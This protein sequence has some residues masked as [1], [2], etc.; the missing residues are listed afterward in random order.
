MCLIIVKKVGKPMPTQAILSIAFDNNPDGFGIAYTEPDWRY[1]RIIKG[2]MSKK[3]MHKMIA[4]IPQPKKKCIIFHFRYATEGQV[5][6]ENCHPF[7]LSNRDEDLASLDITTPMA[8]A[9]NGMIWDTG[10]DW[11][12]I[13]NDDGLAVYSWKMSVAQSDTQKYIKNYLWGMGSSLFNR[14]VCKLVQAH[15]NS[16]FV[17]LS[18]AKHMILGDFYIKDGLLFSNGSY[19]PDY[20]KVEEVALPPQQHTCEICG[21]LTDEQIPFAGALICSHCLTSLI[22]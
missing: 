14:Q 15:S 16:K 10:E 11:E 4:Q 9:H 3:R 18:P 5:K 22:D 2:A 12:D 17:F 21:E 7:P 20:Y 19:L 6:P 1:V 13:D 8:I